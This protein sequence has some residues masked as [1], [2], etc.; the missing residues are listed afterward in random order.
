[1]FADK[2]EFHLKSILNTQ[3]VKTGVNLGSF[4]DKKGNFHV[5]I[6][7]IHILTQVLSYVRDNRETV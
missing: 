1:M 4:N 7:Y 2:N 5:D 6:E 3:Q